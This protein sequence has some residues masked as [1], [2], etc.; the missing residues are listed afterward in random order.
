VDQEPVKEAW[1]QL[2]FVEVALLFILLEGT[3]GPA[4]ANKGFP[5]LMLALVPA[6]AAACAG[7][8]MLACLGAAV[9]PKMRPI[10][11]KKGPPRSG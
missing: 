10:G 4:A 11:T 2:V 8:Y 7:T 9:A 6:A 5:S 3:F 1:L